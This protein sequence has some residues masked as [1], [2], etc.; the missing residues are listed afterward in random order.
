MGITLDSLDMKID[1]NN[2]MVAETNGYLKGVIP[3]LATKADLSQ[4]IATHA[5]ECS[6]RINVPSMSGVNTKVVLTLASVITALVTVIGL[7]VGA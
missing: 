6:G 4:A 7:L 5:K 2:K 3:N 1:D